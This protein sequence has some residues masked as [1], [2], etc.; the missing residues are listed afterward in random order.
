MTELSP[1]ATPASSAGT[2]GAT[3]GVRIALWSA[4][5]CVVLALVCIAWIDRPVVDFAHAHTQGTPWIQHVAELPAPLFILAWPA[6][7]IV[8]AVWLLRRTLPAWAIT[9]W[10]AAGAVGVG[11]LAKQA[12]KFVFGRTWPATWIHE[13]PSYLRDGV[14]TFKFFGGGNAAYASFPSG[15]LTV[16]LAFTTVLALRHRRLRV[17]CAIAIALTAF[18]QLASAYHWTSDALAGAAL[19]IAIGSAF[20]AAWRWWQSNRAA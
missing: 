7:L 15:H 11:S 17:P 5:G 6:F 14:F 1:N 8:G 16:M 20:V 4:M 12:L 3:P 18:G 10:L 2:P 19:G 13:N 9:L